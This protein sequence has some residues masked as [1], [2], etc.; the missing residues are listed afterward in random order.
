MTGCTIVHG[1]GWR[2]DQSKKKCHATAIAWHDCDDNNFWH[3][4]AEQTCVKACE[5][6]AA[7]QAFMDEYN[8][9]SKT[10]VMW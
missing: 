10:V 1:K 8:R 9:I 5:G 3:L 6:Q 4:A 2:Y 7:Y